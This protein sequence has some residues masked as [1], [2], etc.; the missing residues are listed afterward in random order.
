ME[1]TKTM[2]FESVPRKSIW[3]KMSDIQ[4]LNI[5][6]NKDKQAHGY[7][8]ATLDQIMDKLA[9]ILHENKLLVIHQTDWDNEEKCSYLKTTVIDTDDATQTISSLTYLDSSVILPGQ[10]KVMVIGSQITYYRRY[11]V[12]SLFGLTTETDTDAGGA[13]PGKKGQAAAAGSVEA[14]GG[15]EKAVD[16]EAIFKNMIAKGKTKDIVQ[17]QFDTYKSKMTTE[18]VTLVT[19]LISEIK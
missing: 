17:K 8:Y 19:A 16:F 10:N 12:T 7:A 3:Q 6:I 15:G 9:P 18:Q 4:G 14:S 2:E 13:M 11:H 1:K 5:Q